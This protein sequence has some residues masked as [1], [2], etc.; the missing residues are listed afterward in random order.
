MSSKSIVQKLPSKWTT[1]PN[2]TKLAF[3]SFL[4]IFFFFFFLKGFVSA[5]TLPIIKIPLNYQNCCLNQICCSDFGNSVS[6]LQQC[7]L[8]F[9]NKYRK[10]L[11]SISCHLLMQLAIEQS[12]LCA[13]KLFPG[14]LACR[15][16]VCYDFHPAN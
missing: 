14:R 10:S 6:R 1:L 7:L 8:H 15:V 9:F 4:S 13:G 5:S 12:T 2:L 16:K 11:F 3:F